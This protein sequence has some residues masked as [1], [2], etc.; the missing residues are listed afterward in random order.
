MLAQLRSSLTYANVMATVAVFVA[1]GGTSYAIATG[2]IDSRE[3]KNNTVRSK[4]I[5]DNTATTRDLR[6]NSARGID[7]RNNSLTGADVLES[8]L[9]TVPSA[10]SA[11]RANTANSANAATSADTAGN[12]SALGGLGPDAFARSSSIRSGQAD[13]GAATSQTIVDLPELSGALVTDGDID[14]DVDFFLRNNRSAGGGDLFI[15]CTPDGTPSPDY[16]TV[17]PGAM[18]RILFGNHVTTCVVFDPAGGAANYFV[19]CQGP[20]V[21]PDA[22]TIRCLAIRGGA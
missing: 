19:Q 22:V 18:E 5:R 16:A 17:A 15:L 3:I 21:A 6:N 9:G 13:S 20:A 1:L 10:G 12:A 4:D 7:V 2:S 8:S 11:D 14:H